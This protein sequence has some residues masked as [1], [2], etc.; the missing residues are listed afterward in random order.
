MNVLTIRCK[1]WIIRMNLATKGQSKF[2]MKNGAT[3]K[4]KR[5]VPK[6]YA[7]DLSFVNAKKNNRQ[8][9]EEGNEDQKDMNIDAR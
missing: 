8:I 6:K 3:L 2:L 9:N 5:A 7:A 4:R 1:F